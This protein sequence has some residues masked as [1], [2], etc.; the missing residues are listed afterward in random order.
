M[1]V[2]MDTVR[3]SLDYLGMWQERERG[4]G[5]GA[6]SYTCTRT[7]G[8]ENRR[9]RLL[10]LLQPGIKAGLVLDLPSMRSREWAE[11]LVRSLNQV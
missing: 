1:P 9:S 3:A 4:G 8:R 10:D 6:Y 11:A 7:F 2:C 5:D